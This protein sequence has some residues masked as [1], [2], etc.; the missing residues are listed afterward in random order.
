MAPANEICLCHP[1][2][3]AGHP[4][5]ERQP[6]AAAGAR[7]MQPLPKPDSSLGCNTDGGRPAGI[8]RRRHN[9]DRSVH[10]RARAR[11]P[12]AQELM[13]PS[14]RSIDAAILVT[15][16]AVLYLGARAASQYYREWSLGRSHEVATAV[17]VEVSSR[18]VRGGCSTHV[19]FE[20]SPAGSPEAVETTHAFLATDDP[21]CLDVSWSA[22]ETMQVA[23][24][25][26][27]PSIHRPYW[28]RLGRGIGPHEWK[29]SAVLAGLLAT[30]LV[31]LAWLRR[32][33]PNNPRQQ[34]G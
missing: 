20:F 31:Y 23:Y 26:E 12:P 33:R 32:R 8:R 13:Q 17:A 10:S 14:R 22:G 25:P 15:G 21:D 18:K 30:P 7:R 1:P 6:P 3:P 2:S 16:V 34:A 29:L 27:D 19:R 24:V 28:G 5:P 9:K 4:A 11:C